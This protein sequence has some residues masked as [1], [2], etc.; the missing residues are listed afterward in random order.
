[1]QQQWSMYNPPPPTQLPAKYAHYAQHNQQQQAAPPMNYNTGNCA[2]NP[3]K[4]HDNMWYCH[5]CGFDVDHDG[6]NCQ[7]RRWYHQANITR[8]MA[9]QLMRDDKW[10]GCRKGAKK[11]Q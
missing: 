11:N 8:E 2:P 10:P 4:Y 3:K 7:K 1:M 5:S 6:R 9:K